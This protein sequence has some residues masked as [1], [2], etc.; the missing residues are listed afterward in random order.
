MSMACSRCS[1]SAGAVVAPDVSGYAHSRRRQRSAAIVGG[2]LATPVLVAFAD[3]VAHA[4]LGPH[5]GNC[6]QTPTFRR[7]LAPTRAPVRLRADLGVRARVSPSGA[8][9]GGYLSASLLFFG[10]LG[11]ISP[12]RRGLRL[13]LFAWIVLVVARMYGEPPLLG[14]V[15]GVLPGMSRV[16]FFR[17]GAPAL[18]M[19]VIVLAA[20]GLDG[21]LA[22]RIPRRRVLGVTA[23]ALVDRRSSGDRSGAAGAPV[24]RSVPSLLLKGVGSLGGCRHRRGCA[25][26][27]PA[28]LPRTPVAGNGDLVP[29]CARHVRAAPA[30]RTTEHRHRYGPSSLPPAQPRSLALLHAR[31]P[32][33]E[34]RQ[35]LRD[36]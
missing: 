23:G 28:Q 16:A 13:V 6:S 31:T 25:R 1:G 14:H 18:E 32:R 20:L 15:L 21:L 11:L 9:L 8:E 19:A 36:S 34:L 2:L 10:L 3:Y 29:R 12:G 4:D 17:Y 30:I 24:H 5:A 22:N 26:R 33:T 35:L 27:D 7:R